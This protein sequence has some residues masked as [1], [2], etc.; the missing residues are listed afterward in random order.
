MVFS[1]IIGMFLLPFILFFHPEV[2]SHFD[3]KYILISLN[4]FFYVLAVLPYFYALQK[5]DVSTSAALFQ[6]IPIFSY[7][8]SFLILGETLTKNQ[9]IGGLVI[10]TGAIMMSLDLTFG[11]KVKFKKEVFLLM[12]LS[13]SLFAF[14]FSIFKLFAIK[15]QFWV[16]S[17]WEYLGFAIFAF[18]LLVFIK[19]YRQEFLKVI[20]TNS[21]SVL[22]LNSLNEIINI[23]AKLSFN[24]ASLLVPVTLVWVIDGLQPFFIFIYGIILTIFFPK[25]SQEN[26]TKKII[27]QKIFA[28]IIMFLGT[29]LINR[30]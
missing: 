9:I 8:L 23:I 30:N 5:D 19:P 16:T 24:L 3:F 27:I 2:I 11:K 25:I 13:S 20:K 7:I 28:I 15:A 22:T 12:A 10:I 26:I 4:G 6:L 29:Y 14:N 18:L 1:S 21:I 17:F